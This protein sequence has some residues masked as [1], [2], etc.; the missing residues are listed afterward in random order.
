MMA[1]FFMMVPLS[2]SVTS[3]AISACGGGESFRTG[4]QAQVGK[5]QRTHLSPRPV[6][7]F[8]SVFGVRKRWFPPLGKRRK[9]A[10]QT[11]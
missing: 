6:C 5:R 3:A 1:N 10:P 9:Q 4:G 8:F 11:A 2:D 7:G